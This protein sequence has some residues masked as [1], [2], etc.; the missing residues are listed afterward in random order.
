MTAAPTTQAPSGPLGGV[1]TPKMGQCVYCGE[2]FQINPKAEKHEHCS[3]RCRNAAWNAKHPRINAMTE[4]E[5]QNGLH[6]GTVL[7]ISARNA[8]ISAKSVKGGWKYEFK[9]E[10]TEEDF[11]RF[12]GHD[13]TGSL[14]E[15]QLECIEIAQLPLPIEPKPEAPKGGPLAESA[16]RLCQ[17]PLFW[18]F[19]S[20]QTGIPRCTNELA[21]NYVRE[22]CGVLSRAEI[23]HQPTAKHRFMELMGEFRKWQQ[24]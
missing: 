7:Q 3:D 13:L 17:Q 14:F 6:V 8:N 9:A 10:I 19:L 18:D 21:T 4:T 24:G 23:D 5:D 2:P 11:L 12:N 15:A 22:Y 16:G 20:F 1:A